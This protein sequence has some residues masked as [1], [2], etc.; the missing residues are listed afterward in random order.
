MC[1]RDSNLRTHPTHGLSVPTPRKY[2][3]D[4]HLRSGV[5]RC[6]SRPKTKSNSTRLA[7]GIFVQQRLTRGGSQN[8]PDA[9]RYDAQKALR[10]GDLR[11]PG[12]DR[13]R[14][15]VPDWYRICESARI[16]YR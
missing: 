12:I 16:E 2:R 11:K 7:R 8:E 10:Q 14:G 15:V 5:L 9:Q 1:I 6:S 4:A 13:G 3:L